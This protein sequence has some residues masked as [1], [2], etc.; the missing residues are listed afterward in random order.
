M[1]IGHGI[2]QFHDNVSPFRFRGMHLS[3][4]VESGAFNIFLYY[5]YAQP[6]NFLERSYMHHPGI[7]Q[8]HEHLELLA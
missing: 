5:A 1:D 8:C 2:E 7:A 4:L 3:P 6:A